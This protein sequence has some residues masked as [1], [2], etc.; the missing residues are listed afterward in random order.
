MVCSFE[1]RSFFERRLRGRIALR[2][3]GPGL[4][5]RQV[6]PL[7]QAGEPPLAIA[8]AIGSLEIVTQI[9][10]SPGA[11]PIALR[12]RSPQDMGFQRRLLT[13]TELLRATSPGPH[14][15]CEPPG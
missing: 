11:D 10:Q 4:L 14:D 6:Q 8:D 2:V 1:G 5:A 15:S 12:L 7:E 3:R 9:N 13:G